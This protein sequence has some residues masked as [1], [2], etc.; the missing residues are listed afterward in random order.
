MKKIAPT[1]KNI[2]GNVKQPELEYKSV[3]LFWKTDTT[4]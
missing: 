2:G 3:Y 1:K 4:F